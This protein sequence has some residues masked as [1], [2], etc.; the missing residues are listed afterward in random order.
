VEQLRLEHVIKRYGSV[1]AVDDIS[2]TVEGG[3]FITLLGPSGCG[4]TTT[5]RMIGGL[6]APTSGRVYIQ[7][8]DMTRVPA[9][10]RPT[11]MVFQSYALFPHLTVFN[12]IVFGL[13]N[14][15]IPK[16]VQREKAERI[17]SLVHLEG[18][19]DRRPNEL[20][21]GQQQRVA[22]A[23]ALVNEP[24]VLLLDEPLGALDAKLRKEMRFEL[25]RIQHELGVSFIFVTHDQEEAIS[26]SDRIVLMD[27]GIIE[28]EGTPRE[29]FERPANRFVADFVGVG[30]SVPGECVERSNGTVVVKCLDGSLVKVTSDEAVSPGAEATVWVRATEVRLGS[31]LNGQEAQVWQGRVGQLLYYGDQVDLVVLLANS[32]EIRV[33]ISA[34]QFYADQIQVGSEVSVGWEQEKGRLFVG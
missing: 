15:K 18:L 17:L 20:S 32:L 27:E 22:L 25:K 4:K 28:Q 33:V 21:G 31:G 14:Q 16:A 34:E 23:R 1:T 6:E 3:E 13:K 29:I 10:K 8:E 11:N 30:N 24:A 2:L 19:D 12:N 9:F 7:G 26:L 5:L